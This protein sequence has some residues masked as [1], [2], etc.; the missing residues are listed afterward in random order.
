[1]ILN[2]TNK[3][4]N[5]LF[6]AEV[7]IAEVHD[8]LFDRDSVGIVYRQII[9]EGEQLQ[10]WNDAMEKQVQDDIVRCIRWRNKN[11]VDRGQIQ[12]YLEVQYKE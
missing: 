1:V 7:I 8:E 11:R 10:P 3:S 9:R 2:N 12:Q 5:K 6:S 4:D